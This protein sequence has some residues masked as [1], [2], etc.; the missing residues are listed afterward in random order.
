MLYSTTEARYK[1]K[2]IVLVT[3]ARVLSISL[4]IEIYKTLILPVVLYVCETWSLTLW[5]E[6]RL[7][8]FGLPKEE[9]VRGWRRLHIEEFY[10]L[11][12]SPNVIRVIKS[13]WVR[14]AGKVTCMGE[15]RNAYSVLV[16]KP[17]R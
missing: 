6:C 8:V 16:G 4:K 15:M 10:D 5:E 13:R 14:W 17:G 3:R 12:T 9:V 11:Y 2:Y 7:R 1:T